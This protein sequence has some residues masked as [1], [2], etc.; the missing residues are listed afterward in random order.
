MY[1]TRGAIAATLRFVL[2]LPKQSEIVFNFF[3]PRESVGA[4]EA[5]VWAE[6]AAFIGPLVVARGEPLITRFEPEELQEWLTQLGFAKLYLL[7]P[8]QAE[9]RYFVGRHDG[10]RALQAA[11]LLRATV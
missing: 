11:L 5:K 7:S 1:L 3:R 9:E 10:L 6:V 2:S 4:A 8:E